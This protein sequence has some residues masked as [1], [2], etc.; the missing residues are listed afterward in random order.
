MCLDVEIDRA[1]AAEVALSVAEDKV[2]DLTDE[3]EGLLVALRAAH[4]RPAAVSE[5]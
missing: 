5:S 3:R 4:L 1:N 2:Q